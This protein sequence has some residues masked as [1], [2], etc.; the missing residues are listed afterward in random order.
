MV[1]FASIRFAEARK[2]PGYWTLHAGNGAFPIR[3]DY[4]LDDGNWDC[5]CVCSCRCCDRGTL[6]VG[7]MLTLIERRG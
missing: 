7:D 2:E 5:E 6:L 1:V 4:A 3:W